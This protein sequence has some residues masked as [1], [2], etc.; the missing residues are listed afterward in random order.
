MIK[1]IKKFLKIIFIAEM[2]K[3]GV[4]TMNEV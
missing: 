3:N 4:K 2:V 1:L